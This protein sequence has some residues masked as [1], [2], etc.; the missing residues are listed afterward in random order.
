MM[1]LGPGTRDPEEAEDRKRLDVL[2]G[3]TGKPRKETA[4]V[5]VSSTQLYTSFSSILLGLEEI[6]E[7][8]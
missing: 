3:L 5:T 4:S 7:M 1:E 2:M 6:S 8:I